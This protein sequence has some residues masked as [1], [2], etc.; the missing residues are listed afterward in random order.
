MPLPFLWVLVPTLAVQFGG[1][2]T[3]TT[4]P[5]AKITVIARGPIAPELVR[6][7][8]VEMRQSVYA[9]MMGR[10]R[11]EDALRSEDIAVEIKRCLLP[12]EDEEASISTSIIMSMTAGATTVMY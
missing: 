11:L 12:E 10:P 6:M 8:V 3:W 9:L 4:K 7:H 1:R 5:Y 2:D